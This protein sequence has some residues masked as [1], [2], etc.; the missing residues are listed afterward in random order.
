M[1]KGIYW[2]S[3]ASVAG[4][5]V[6][7]QN[8][9]LIER[10]NSTELWHIPFNKASGRFVQ[11]S[12]SYLFQRPFWMGFLRRHALKGS[13]GMVGRWNLLGN[14]IGSHIGK[15]GLPQGTYIKRKG[16]TRGIAGKSREF[17]H[18]LN[19]RLLWRKRQSLIVPSWCWSFG[20]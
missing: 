9:R 11:L 20:F 14:R 19:G 8:T 17:N 13:V 15:P 6:W 12:D 1:I 7:P 3:P 10:D 2:T 16:I 18:V 4:V 5:N